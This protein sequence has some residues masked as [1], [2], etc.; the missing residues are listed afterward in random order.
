MPACILQPGHGQINP[1]MTSLIAGDKS[2]Y[3]V[4]IA[5]TY[6]RTCACPARARR[7]SAALGRPLGG[8]EK[9]F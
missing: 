3:S 6:T 2:V 7:G 4:V 1:K 9:L 5:R 8:V